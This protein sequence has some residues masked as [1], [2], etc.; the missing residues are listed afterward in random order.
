MLENNNPMDIPTPLSSVFLANEDSVDQSPFSL[1]LNLNSINFTSST[2]I[3]GVT[4]PSYSDAFDVSASI[5]MEPFH[6]QN[7]QDALTAQLNLSESSLLGFPVPSNSLNLIENDDSSRYFPP[8]F[9][10]E[11]VTPIPQ[12]ASSANSGS[13]FIRTPVNDYRPT[14]QTSGSKR[15]QSIRPINSHSFFNS[16][17]KSPGKLSPRFKNSSRSINKRPGR[18][19]PLGIFLNF[20]FLAYIEIL[21]NSFIIKFI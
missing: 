8:S 6:T 5:T 20:L 17:S 16:P 14:R 1:N 12:F 10:Q 4:T 7:S 18:M 15:K 9:N 2:A 11:A 3:T 13:N 21:I 19:R